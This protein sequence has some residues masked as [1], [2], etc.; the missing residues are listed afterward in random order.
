MLTLF[1]SRISA[2]PLLSRQAA[3][4]RRALDAAL[5]LSAMDEH[6]VGDDGSGGGG[7]Y[8]ESSAAYVTGSRSRHAFASMLELKPV[9]P[10][11]AAAGIGAAAEVAAAALAS[12]PPAALVHRIDAFDCLRLSLATP[13]VRAWRVSNGSVGGDSTPCCLRCH[14]PP[15]GCAAA[16]RQLP[17]DPL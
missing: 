10:D 9:T 2:V 5:R 6:T 15:A 14:P 3:T 16:L 11:L 13:T 7:G 12:E 17:P 4:L 8:P 1:E